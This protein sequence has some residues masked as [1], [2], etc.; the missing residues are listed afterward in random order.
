MLVDL[1]VGSGRIWVLTAKGIMLTTDD[2][3]AHVT[4]P[5]LTRPPAPR[6]WR[7]QCLSAG[8]GGLANAGG[9]TCAAVVGRTSYTTAVAQVCDTDGGPECVLGRGGRAVLSNLYMI[10]S[11]ERCL[12]PRLCVQFFGSCYQS[13]QAILGVPLGFHGFHLGSISKNVLFSIGP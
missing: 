1:G 13:F 3:A 9:S 4:P 11:C 7:G 6:A 12:G 8:R 5:A 2:T 10:S